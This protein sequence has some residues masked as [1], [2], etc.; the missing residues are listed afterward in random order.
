MKYDVRVDLIRLFNKRSEGEVINQKLW[1]YF[2]VS[3]DMIESSY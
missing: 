1:F 2:M 3:Y